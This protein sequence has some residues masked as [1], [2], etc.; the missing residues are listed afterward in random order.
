MASNENEKK[1]GSGLVPAL[2]IVTLLGAGGGYFVI[3]K[4][5]ALDLQT[6]SLEASKAVVPMVVPRVIDV[7]AIVTSIGDTQQMIRLQLSIVVDRGAP[8]GLTGNDFANDMIAYIRT[9][10]L[11][12]LSGSSGL[13]HLRDDLRERAD[14]RA[15]G[16]VRDLILH[17][18]VI[19]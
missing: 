1:K 2:G 12:Q 11:D 5:G 15:A 16:Q 13:E 17:D 14:I 3:A 10:S 7:P 4:G 19:Q 9:I 18:L 8:E 6:S